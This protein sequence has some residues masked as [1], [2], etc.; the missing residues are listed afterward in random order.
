MV[1]SNT[2]ESAK[3]VPISSLNASL[4]N[5]KLRTAGILLSY[6]HEHQLLIVHDGANHACLIDTSLILDSMLAL[7]GLRENKTVV[8]V[9][10]YLEHVEGGLPIPIIPAFVDAPVIDPTLI[11]RAILVTPTPDLNLGYWE[12][13][14]MQVDKGNE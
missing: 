3:P 6:D 11:V 14:I 2:P 12:H 7:P 5:E 13:A 1:N 10:G 9:I 4:V 8:S